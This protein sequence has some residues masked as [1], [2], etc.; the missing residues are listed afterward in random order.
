[1][2]DEF[3]LEQEITLLKQDTTLLNE[4]LAE[5]Q[6]KLAQEKNEAQHLVLVGKINDIQQELVEAQKKLVTLTAQQSGG[7][8]E[9]EQKLGAPAKLHGVPALP[10]YCL[11]AP[12]FNELK[13]KLVVKPT[14]AEG[15]DG[16]KNPILFLAPSGRGKSLQAIVLAHDIS[17]RRAFSEG[18]FWINMGSQ[19][20]IIAHQQALIRAF[21]ISAIGTPEFISAE[22]GLTILRG[23]GKGRAC[24]F[25]LD[26]VY[27]V[28]DVMAFSGLGKACQLLITS[29]HPEI[30]DDLKHFMP[31]LQ[32]YTLEAFTKEQA[33]DYFKQCYTQPLPEPLP[34]D[35]TALFNTCEYSPTALKLSAQL[36]KATAKPDWTGLLTQLQDRTLDFPEAHPVSLLQA[37]HLN[38]EALGD[39]GEYYLTLGV[40]ADYTK[41][42]QAAIV[43]LWRYLYH[44]PDETAY[45]F[46]QQL[47]AQGLL[48]FNSDSPRSDVHLH[49]YQHD[50]LCEFADLDKLHTH[51]LA[52]Y[53]R[54]CQPHGWAKGPDDGYFFEYLCL[55]L[56]AAERTRELKT[57]LMDFDWLNNK[58]RAT[59]LHNLIQDFDLLEDDTDVTTVKQALQRAANVL[60]KDKHKLADKLLEQLWGKPSSDIQTLLNQAKEV[61]PDWHPP[62]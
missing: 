21:N 12:I 48:Y 43:L 50:Y 16:Q 9:D 60:V 37:L 49:P 40:F 57:L 32:S 8:K 31:S 55:H 23:I 5:L 35:L 26:D 58:L 28:R 47:N 38:V 27:D 29:C 22:E 11:P 20:D 34:A 42:P 44:L 59:Y 56:L 62:T 41:I 52:A 1:M 24:L 33:I 39:Y 54:Y 36:A 30:A 61:T 14:L 13:A 46:I 6:Q 17:V 19:P 15:A 53:R 18:I 2:S 25:I 7:D 51:L 4:S 45:N 10:D 3:T